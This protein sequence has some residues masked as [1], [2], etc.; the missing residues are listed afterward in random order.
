MIA[1]IESYLATRRAAGFKLRKAEQ[2][3]RAYA[4]EAS[5]RKERHVR[6][7]TAIEW[8]SAASTVDARARRLHHVI[9][10]A[11]YAKAE[12]DGHE[13][14][15][16]RVFVRTRQRPLPYIFSGQE[17]RAIL[18]EARMLR[19]AD[20]IKPHT[21]C[22]LFGL[23]ASCGLRISEA[24][25]LKLVDVT[26]DGL[27]VRYAK[28]NKSRLVPLHPTTA[29]ALERYLDRR[30]SVPTDDDHLLVIQTGRVPA[31]ETVV[32]VFLKIVRKLGIHPGPGQRGPRLHDFR[33]S[34][35]VRVLESTSPSPGPT[36]RQMLALSTYLGHAKVADT[37]WY[38][39]AT[40]RLMHTIADA[41]E[42][43][44]E[45]C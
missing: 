31:Y 41:C 21:Y 44:M 32:A 17:I 38:L 5:R 42:R 20:T 23:L 18:D 24:L 28:F 25:G 4:S 34:F 43:H 1:L 7:R 36:S 12:D 15:P 3:L 29:M 35:A 19:P 39:Q 40:P 45:R 10:F 37:Y 33:H 16:A 30:R 2:H 13:I 11:R 22:T 6:A 14:P 9:H 26:E 27:V 8:A